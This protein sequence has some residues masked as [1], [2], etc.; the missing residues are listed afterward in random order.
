MKSLISTIC[1]SLACIA[2]LVSVFGAEGRGRLHQLQRNLVDQ[3][4]KNEELGGQV[5]D[6][7][8]RVGG[9]LSDNRVLE[10]EARNKLGLARP[11]EMVFIFEDKK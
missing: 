1:L 4:Q 10:K 6:L 11:D 2:V 9:I 3:K 7:R 8:A 5:D